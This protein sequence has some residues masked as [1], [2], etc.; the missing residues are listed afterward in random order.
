[1]NIIKSPL[2]Q[3]FLIV[4]R[5]AQNSYY[6]KGSLL[7]GAGMNISHG[8]CVCWFPLPGDGLKG[9]LAFSHPQHHIWQTLKTWILSKNLWKLHSKD[10]TAYSEDQKVSTILHIVFRKFTCR[11]LARDFSWGKTS[12]YTL[13]RG[14]L[15][16]KSIHRGWHQRKR[17]EHCRLA[18]EAA[19]YSE[20]IRS[21]SHMSSL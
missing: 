10:V 8:F 13:T 16:M 9:Q 21:Y 14:A 20:E 1:M 17:L 18:S 15:E 11:N 12:E 6:S 5:L 3:V 19:E 4:I 7:I 2:F